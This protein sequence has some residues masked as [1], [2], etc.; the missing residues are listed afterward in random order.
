MQDEASQR[1]YFCRINLRNNCSHQ[2]YELKFYTKAWQ[3]LQHKLCLYC[4][5]TFEPRYQTDQEPEY[6]KSMYDFAGTVVE[7]QNVDERYPTLQRRPSQAMRINSRKVNKARCVIFVLYMIALV[8]LIPQ[9]FE[10]RLSYIE[11]QHKTYV[12]TVITDFGRQR[13]FRQIFH[14]WFYLVAIY[15]L[16]F[17]LILIFNL[18]LLRTYLISKKVCIFEIF[19]RFIFLIQLALEK[20]SKIL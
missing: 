2:T 15:I 20:N 18:L 7:V 8:Y 16:P 19:K 3:Y 12:F 9:M 5:C 17:F 11:I 6:S 4:F 10:K 13:W 14:L 1:N